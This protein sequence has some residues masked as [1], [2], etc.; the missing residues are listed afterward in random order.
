MH[1][2]VFTNDLRLFDNKVLSLVRS[3][4]LDAA[5]ALA[6]FVVNPSQVSNTSAHKHSSANAIK[7]MVES[8]ESLDSELRAAGGRLI[9][10]TPESF[11]GLLSKPNISMDVR[12]VS[13]SKSITLFG[14]ARSNRLREACRKSGITLVEEWD[15]PLL[16]PFTKSNAFPAENVD[17]VGEVEKTDPYVIFSSFYKRA[18][19]DYLPVDSGFSLSKLGSSVR[20]FGKSTPHSTGKAIKG[21]VNVLESDSIDLQSIGNWQERYSPLLSIKGGRAEGLLALRGSLQKF[22]SRDDLST[23]GGSGLSAYLN[24]GCLSPREVYNRWLSSGVNASYLGGSEEAIRQLVWRDFYH[25]LLLVPANREYT[26]LDPTYRSIK[27]G[28]D[29]RLYAALWDSKT[30]FHMVDAAMRQLRLSGWM[31]NRMRLIWSWFCIKILHLD[32]FHRDMGAYYIFSRLLVDACA[33][34]NKFNFEWIIS[35]LDLAGR[36]FSRG[37]PMAGRYFDV[38]VKT[39]LKKNNAKAWLDEW[40]PVDMRVTT[41]VVD[42]DKQYAKWNSMVKRAR[43][44]S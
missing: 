19:S 29:P 22:M 8:L 25:S 20:W 16:T 13:I 33:S 40:L 3:R 37:D 30:G 17:A 11:F 27:W 1:I 2:H 35:T 44:S 42:L 14:S 12:S 31:P 9:V 18:V 28:N 39:G 7:F 43:A 15:F 41:P 5:G 23:G 34:Q 38:S 26:W 21:V 32:P 10:T 4:K 24:F 6:V 36:R